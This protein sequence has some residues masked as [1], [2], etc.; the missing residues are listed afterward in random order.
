VSIHH[1]LLDIV[2][3]HVKSKPID[4]EQLESQGYPKDK[5][6]KSPLYKSRKLYEDLMDKFTSCNYE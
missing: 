6:I 3:F 1:S 2:L 4:F 5:V